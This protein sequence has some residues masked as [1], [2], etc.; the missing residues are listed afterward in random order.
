MAGG[1]G[2]PGGA[3]PGPGTTAREKHVA[4]VLDGITVDVATARALACF[5]DELYRMSR[6]AFRGASGVLPR[7]L[8]PNAVRVL[9]GRK[10]AGGAAA[11]VYQGAWDGARAAAHCDSDA[12]P[13]GSLVALKVKYCM[14]ITPDTVSGFCYE[15]AVHAHMSAL[16][17]FVLQLY[18]VCVA[19]PSMSLVFRLCRCSLRDHLHTTA[20]TRLGWPRRLRM[21]IECVRAVAAIHS[22]GMLHN[23]IKSHNFLI[24]DAV[25]DRSVNDGNDFRCVIT[26]FE[27]STPVRPDGYSG[28]VGDVDAAD[29]SH[30]LGEGARLSRE[31]EMRHER[32]LKHGLDDGS[33]GGADT[34]RTPLLAD[35]GAGAGA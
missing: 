3:D 22:S 27:L 26:D 4:S 33:Q 35:A 1:R 20:G 28:V 17:P 25:P 31:R 21:M 32:G 13:A 19:P 6:R 24:D 9:S 23:D 30:V 8:A 12:A 15:A 14:D 34:L 7:S 5:E 11:Q 18:G 29:V 16:S 2:R 10:I